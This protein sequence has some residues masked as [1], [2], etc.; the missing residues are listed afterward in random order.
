MAFVDVFIATLKTNPCFESK[1]NMCYGVAMFRLLLLIS[2]LGFVIGCGDE[3]V[4]EPTVMETT[5]AERRVWFGDATEDDLDILIAGHY[6]EITGNLEISYTQ[7]DTITLPHLQSV[8]GF[9]TIDGNDNL[10][11][12]DLPQLQSVGEISISDNNNLTSITVPQLQSVSGGVYIYDSTTL[13]SIDFPQL[14]SVGASVMIYDNGSLTTI[15]LSR[16]KSVG[17]YVEIARNDN[18]TTIDLTQLESVGRSFRIYRHYNLTTIAMPQLE[19]VGVDLSMSNNA[20]LTAIDLPQ[21]HSVGGAVNV[22]NNSLTSCNLGSY[23]DEHCP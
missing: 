19:S 18:L 1:V 4:S 22:Y 20:A 12:V 2:C 21:L 11:G 17:E 10:T 8:S 15:D 5:A 9:F 7:I 3:S 14:Q 6:T 23:T 13:T 16:L